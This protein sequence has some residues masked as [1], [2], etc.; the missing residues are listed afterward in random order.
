MR[1]GFH[2]GTSSRAPTAPATTGEPGGV[3]APSSW[4]DRFTLIRM[5]VAFFF[6]W[7]FLTKDLEARAARRA[8]RLTH[9]TPPS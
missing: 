7:P 2:H 1:A 3:E 8:V 5:T 6:P 4:R 9:R